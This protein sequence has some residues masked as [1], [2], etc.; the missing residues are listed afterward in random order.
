MQAEE[1]AGPK[2]NA[3][4]CQKLLNSKVEDRV[5]ELWKRKQIE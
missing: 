3:D 4:E 2:E 1:T 5:T